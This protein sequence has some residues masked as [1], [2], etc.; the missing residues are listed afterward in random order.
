MRPSSSSGSN[1]GGAGLGGGAWDGFAIR[2]RKSTG[3]KPP[4]SDPSLTES[5]HYISA[6]NP[7]PKPTR[8][9]LLSSR[10]R[11]KS[12]FEAASPSQQRTHSHSIPGVDVPL[13]MTK[14][15]SEPIAAG[16]NPKSTP[17]QAHGDGARSDFSTADRT[18]FAELKRNITAR[19]A[20]FVFKGAHSASVSNP[21]IHGYN[22]DPQNFNSLGRPS[23]RKHH[24]YA[25]EVCPYPRSYDREVLD[26]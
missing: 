21:A 19:A 14:S 2:R 15:Y 3:S 16:S 25:K 1:A 9:L 12:H 5:T 11:P 24:P 10:A 17:G 4:G 13:P 23:G 18:I 26:L 22:T 7:N 6:P 8:S 20:Q